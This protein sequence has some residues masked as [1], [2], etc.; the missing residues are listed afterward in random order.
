[1]IRITSEGWLPRDLVV[2]T[3]D[4]R[5]IKCISSIRITGDPD[6]L[7]TATIEIAVE[8]LDVHAHPLLGIDTLTASADALGMRLVPK[9]AT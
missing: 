2:T 4:G 6:S 3:E 5:E 9:E 8:K 1:M 7:L